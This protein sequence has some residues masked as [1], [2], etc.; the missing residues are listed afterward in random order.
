MEMMLTGDAISGSEAAQKGFANRAFP[1]AE[2]EMRVLEVAERVAKIP[3]ELQQINKRSMHRAMEVM[4]VR[5]AI[6]AGTELQALAFTT[7]AS[8]AYL[9]EFRK[10]VRQTL[11]LP[12]TRPL[13]IITNGKRRI[14]R[15]SAGY[16]RS[17][18]PSD[19]AGPNTH[20]RRYSKSPAPR[21]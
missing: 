2:L 13:V 14:R 9:K 3:T 21:D 5:A 15:L 11:S 20:A 1:A 12:V 4:G 10:G 7:D 19:H 17:P 6:R 8:R 18:Q 16:V